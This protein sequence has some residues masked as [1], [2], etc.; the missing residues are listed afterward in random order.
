M[1]DVYILMAVVLFICALMFYFVG[2]RPLLNTVDYRTIADP[3]A[4][5]KYVGLRMFIPALVAAACSLISYYEPKF[6]LPLLMSIPLS[7]LGVVIWVAIG[8]KKFSASS[9][10]KSGSAA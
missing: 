9:A 6:A 10:V 7:V 3:S 1:F 2:S 4:F 5:N 8:T